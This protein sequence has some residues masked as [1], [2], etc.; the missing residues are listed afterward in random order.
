MSPSK[1]LAI[2]ESNGD[3]RLN[4]GKIKPNPSIDYLPGRAG[5]FAFINK[6]P[7]SNGRVNLRQAHM[8]QSPI[9]S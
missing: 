3:C 7:G 2:D 5:G 8:R 4:G 1:G 9:V 6:P